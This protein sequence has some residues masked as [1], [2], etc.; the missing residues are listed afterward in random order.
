MPLD[1]V[2]LSALAQEMEG[3]LVGGRIDKVQQ[4]ESDMLI[5]SLR[6]EGSNLKLLIAAGGGNARVHLTTQSH[7]NPAE[8]PMFCML[9]RKHLVG[10]RVTNVYQPEYERILI[11]ELQGH[12]ELGYASEK[13]LVIELIG[14][15][16]N[17]ILVDGEGRITDCLR[18]MDFGG[19]ALRRMLP[20][21]IYRLPPAQSKRPLLA[22]DSAER[23]KMLEVNDRSLD[24]DK[25]LMN[26]FSGLSPLVCRELA[27]RCGGDY[28]KLPQLLDAF[29]ESVARRELRP[30]MLMEDDRPQDLSFMRIS[31]YG[32]AYQCREMDSFSELLDSFY[33]QRD[34]AE[35]QRRKAR[36]LK[37]TVRT[38]RDRTERKLNLQREELLRTEDRDELRKRAE[39]VTANI[40][41][42]KKGDRLLRCQD[43]Y[44]PEG[45]ETEI[46]LDPLKT[47]QQ[48]A[49]AMYKEYNKLKAAREHLTGF[50]AE[51][52][53][54]LDYLESVLEL[55]DGAEGEKDVSDLRRELET[56][57]YLRKKKSQK[58][59]RSKAQ[60]PRRFVSDEGF[61]ILAGRSN[62]Q[63]D[64]LTTKL[65]RR[66]DIWLHVQ[67]FH[68]SHVIIRCDGLE[69]GMETIRQ[70]A[71]IAVYY[72]QMRGGGKAA[73]DYTRLRFVRK[74]AGSLPGRVI[75]TDYA[76]LSAEGD[77]ELAER[78][79]RKDKG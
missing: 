30:Y 19:D 50:I 11:I 8:P 73:V 2:C 12:D 77:R 17:I 39:L 42:I 72:S 56:T 76:T 51:G 25:W 57:G 44:E 10:A 46:A 16:S 68:G 26:S 35:S 65:G 28:G 53:R 41:R 13:K 70:A 14:R 4:P 43:Y 22:T 74:P 55:L 64:E 15:S 21:S 29:C 31:Q 60:P 9:M 66:T 24:V 23:Q 58:P 33:S 63:N 52:E 20:G 3:R 27:Y 34:R 38:I 7:E 49:A 78:L 18:R 45:P 69:P 37:K 1:A 6:A 54:Q 71:S 79:R 36:E 48:N 5:L 67:S 61:E 75:Y 59:D 40:Y 62:L 47:P 32:G